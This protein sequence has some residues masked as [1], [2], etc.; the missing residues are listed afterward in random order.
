MEMTIF[1]RIKTMLW[2]SPFPLMQTPDSPGFDVTGRCFCVIVFNL[3]EV[4]Q[5]FRVPSDVLDVY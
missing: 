5:I 4:T 3:L 2:Y 1:S